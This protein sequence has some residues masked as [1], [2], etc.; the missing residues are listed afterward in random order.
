MVA[1]TFLSGHIDIARKS[2]AGQE[3]PAY[4]FTERFIISFSPP[5]RYDV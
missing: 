4:D 2:Q 1:R 3:C 5:V